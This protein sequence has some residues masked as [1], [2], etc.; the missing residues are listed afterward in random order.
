LISTGWSGHNIDII[1]GRYIIGNE[2]RHR[3]FVDAVDNFPN[4]NNNFFSEFFSLFR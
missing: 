1:I 2:D 3:R 4:I